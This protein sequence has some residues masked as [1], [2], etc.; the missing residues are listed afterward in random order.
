MPHPEMWEL[1][2]DVPPAL[3]ELG[4]SSSWLRAGFSS[5]PRGA[6]LNLSLCAGHTGS[7]VLTLSTEQMS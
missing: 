2:L 3:R 4:M 1:L 7:P 5:L 6:A